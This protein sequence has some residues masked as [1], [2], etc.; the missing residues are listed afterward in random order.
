[1][2]FGFCSVELK[3]S[4]GTQSAMSYGSLRNYAWHGKSILCSWIFTF[5]SCMQVR[6]H[7]IT[8]VDFALLLGPEWQ[9]QSAQYWQSWAVTSLLVPGKQ[10]CS[11][12][13]PIVAERIRRLALPILD[14]WQFPRNDWQE[15]QDHV[16]T[17]RAGTGRSWVPAFSGLK[18]SGLGTTVTVLCSVC[19]ASEG[20]WQFTPSQTSLESLYGS[21]CSI[22]CLHFNAICCSCR[23]SWPYSHQRSSHQTLY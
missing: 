17:D 9:A 23:P 18:W 4:T 6:N 10:L 13:Y 2:W 8:T 15:S 21:Q 12:C 22:I 20:D 5:E 7:L 14:S 19:W 16:R 11:S 1:M 3:L